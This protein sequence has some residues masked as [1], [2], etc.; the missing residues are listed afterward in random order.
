M[1]NQTLER[2]GIVIGVLAGAVIVGNAVKWY[3]GD[4]TEDPDVIFR[5]KVAVG[6]MALISC[7]IVGMAVY[8]D[9]KAARERAEYMKIL[10]SFNRDDYQVGKKP[11]GLEPDGSFQTPF[12]IRTTMIVDDNGDVLVVD[13]TTGLLV[14]ADPKDE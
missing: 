6:F 1:N 10:E 12:G 2:A 14:R 8:L 11:P 5:L 7:G 3:L 4:L 13:K 9:R